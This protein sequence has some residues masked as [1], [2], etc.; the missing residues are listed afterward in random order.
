[1][2]LYQDT[3]ILQQFYAYDYDIIRLDNGQTSCYYLVRNQFVEVA[4]TLETQPMCSKPE[5]LSVHLCEDT[6]ER[7]S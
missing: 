5:I 4:E 1:M 3:H 6:M 2:T 7:R